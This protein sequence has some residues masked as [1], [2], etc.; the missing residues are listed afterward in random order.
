MVNQ[1]PP[2]MYVCIMYIHV[3]DNVHVIVTYMYMYMYMY[4]VKGEQVVQLPVSFVV[5]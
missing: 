5:E 2:H 3:V 1:L 4:Y